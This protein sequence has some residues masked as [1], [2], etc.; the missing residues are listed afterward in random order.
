MG[1]ILGSHPDT[2]K[3]NALVFQQERDAKETI[4]NIGYSTW[5]RPDQQAYDGVAAALEAGYRHL[6]C[7]EG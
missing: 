2:N 5:N 7:A 6:V 4:P 1:A 3:R